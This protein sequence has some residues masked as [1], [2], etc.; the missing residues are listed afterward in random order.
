MIFNNIKDGYIGNKKISM[1]YL[2]D[3]LLFPISHGVW[4][5][6]KINST[7]TNF[8]VTVVPSGSITVD[9]GDGNQSSA[10]SNQPV[11]HTYVV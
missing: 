2:G 1:I 4:N 11:S 7:I 3:K 10:N 8:S 9:W 5:F 6:N